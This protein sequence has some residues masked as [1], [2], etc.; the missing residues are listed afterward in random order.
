[1]CLSEFYGIGY[2]FFFKYDW[3]EGMQMEMHIRTVSVIHRHQS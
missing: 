1:M 2:C 3:K